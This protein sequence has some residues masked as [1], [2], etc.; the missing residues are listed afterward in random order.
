MKKKLKRLLKNELFGIVTGGAL[1]AVA[2]TLEQLKFNTVSLVFYI[3]ALVFAG[4]GV[5]LDAFRGIMRRDLLDEKFLMTLAAVG[6]MIIGEASEGVAVMLFFL[7][8]EFFEHKAVA[9]SRSSIRSLMEI[10]PDEAR[11]LRDGREELVDSEEVDVGEII[12]IRSGERVPLDCEIISGSVSVDTSALTGESIP[13]PVTVGDRLDSG[14]IVL[15]G[16]LSCRALRIAEESCA[17]RVLELVEYASEKKAP[18]ESFITKFSHYYT[19]AVVIAAL[20]LAVIPPMFSLASFEDSVYRALSFLVVSCP[21]ALVISVPMAFFGGI[22][23]AASQGILFKGG[24]VFSSVARARTIAFDK[25]GTLTTGSFSVGETVTYETEREELFSL[26]A[27]IESCSNH[28]LARTLA[29]LS[30]D[31]REVEGLVELSGR[32]VY[33]YIVGDR[34]AVGNTALLAELGIEKGEKLCTGT[35]LVAKNDE[36]IGEITLSDEI[37]PEAKGS[38]KALRR[39]GISECVMLTGDREDNA[40]PVASALGIDSVKA[41]LSPEEKF[42]YIE[43]ACRIIY[44]GDGINDA[45]AL[46]MADVG[47]AMGRRGSDSAIEAADLVIMSD[48]LTRLPTAIRVARKTVGIAKQNIVFAIGVKLAILALISVGLA[49]MWLAVFADVGVAIIAILNAMRALRVKR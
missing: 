7:V 29:T 21:C 44:V 8:G 22:G 42:S 49:N 14:V 38:I 37:R 48:N 36:I 46:R 15:D 1:F 19:P 16:V 39:L 17:A 27:S 43:S 2:I 40:A 34:I 9:R 33:G 18:E 23:G 30:E 47:V 20:L 13:R 25:T 28:P 4:A 24:A 45:P 35:V 10:K 41:S 11:V 6:A 26:V 3:L 12:V 32:G 5:A 31:I